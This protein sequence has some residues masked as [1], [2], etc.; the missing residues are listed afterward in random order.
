MVKNLQVYS[1]DPSINKRAIHSLISSLKLEFKL[2][3]SFLSISFISSTELRMINKKYLNHNYNTDIITFNYSRK[4]NEIDGEVLIS[5]EEAR[6]N[7]K[8]YNT[9]YSK[10][11]SRLIVHGI[12]HLLNFD[13]N[14]KKNKGIM[15]QMENKLINRYNFTLLAGK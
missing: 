5:F 8:K 14:N 11:I 4:V 15:K 3:I 7:S 9:K 10:E 6:L 1:E 13:D 12:L 2:N